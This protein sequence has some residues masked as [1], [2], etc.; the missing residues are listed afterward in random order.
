MHQIL[1]NVSQ[2]GLICEAIRLVSLALSDVDSITLPCNSVQLTEQSSPLHRELFKATSLLS[3][4]GS[5]FPADLS[6]NDTALLGCALKVTA[7]EASKLGYIFPQSGS[8]QLVTSQR[9]LTTFYWHRQSPEAFR[10]LGTY[11]SYVTPVA[12]TACFFP[13]YSDL[14]GSLNTLGKSLRTLSHVQQ[15]ISAFVGFPSVAYSLEDQLVREPTK[16]YSALQGFLA[17][18]IADGMVTDTLYSFFTMLIERIIRAVFDHASSKQGKLDASEK[19][20]SYYESMSTSKASSV[21]S[22]KLLSYLIYAQLTTNVPHFLSVSSSSLLKKD[23]S[24]LLADTRKE[25][26]NPATVYKALNSCDMDLLRRQLTRRLSFLFSLNDTTPSELKLSGSEF[27]SLLLESFDS[28]SMTLA[29]LEG[30]AMK[31]SYSPNFF[32]MKLL[33]HEEM[34][35]AGVQLDSTDREILKKLLN[36]IITQTSALPTPVTSN[37]FAYPIIISQ[38]A[39][40]Q[41][42]FSIGE[43]ATLAA[44][45]TLPGPILEISAQLNIQL[46]VLIN[47]SLSGEPKQTFSVQTILKPKTLLLEQQRVFRIVLHKH[48]ITQQY[49]DETLAISTF[50]MSYIWQK[51]DIEAVNFKSTSSQTIDYSDLI[52]LQARESRFSSVKFYLRKY[53]EN[54]A[55]AIH[56]NTYCLLKCS[57]NLCAHIRDPLQMVESG[58]CLSSPE[59]YAGKPFILYLYLKAAVPVPPVSLIVTYTCSSDTLPESNINPHCTGNTAITSSVYAYFDERPSLLALGSSNTINIGGLSSYSNNSDIAFIPFI[60]CASDLCHLTFKFILQ[61]GSKK[62][63][64]SPHRGS[65]KNQFFETAPQE[66]NNICTIALHRP[67]EFIVKTDPLQALSV[68]SNGSMLP[69]LVLSQWTK[70]ELTN[71]THD[72]IVTEGVSLTNMPTGEIL[73][74]SALQQ[75][76]IASGGKLSLVVKSNVNCYNPGSSITGLFN[77]KTRFIVRE[78]SSA[79]LEDLPLCCVRYRSAVPY[80]PHKLRGTP[81]EIY[82]TST[83]ATG[84]LLCT[85]VVCHEMPVVD[86]HPTT[87]CP[88]L[89]II[90]KTEAKCRV[91]AAFEYMCEVFVRDSDSYTM[92][93][94]FT[95]PPPSRSTATAPPLEIVSDKTQLCRTY[96]LSPKAKISAS[97]TLRSKTD[98]LHMTPELLITLNRTAQ[99]DKKWEYVYHARRILSV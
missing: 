21:A 78:H 96:T 1:V 35:E 68:F 30:R 40:N 36:G 5:I 32:I 12:Y 33:K 93:I 31:T 59:V 60:V 66:S 34:Q 44:E 27:L 50:K 89:I 11:F 97:V 91:G 86:K 81:F 77:L 58:Y 23:V 7:S 39:W 52:T 83:E 10:C 16:I 46:H 22:I 25:L 45:L 85:G 9:L 65:A 61:L 99:H 15:P 2:I 90:D 74:P 55:E 4:L 92:T 62:V 70:V 80:I 37:S 28:Y 17:S 88:F 53:K 26:I 43:S 54:T 98:G 64:L 73:S 63:S 49:S 29:C 13:I 87:N 19:L 6:E 48:T 76:K 84:P 18:K 94:R 95:E 72:D 14:L 57:E 38:L 75:V 47:G 8:S 67:V 71:K 82:V 56:K 41:P 3:I 24:V 79:K 20:I 51:A 42:S 69:P